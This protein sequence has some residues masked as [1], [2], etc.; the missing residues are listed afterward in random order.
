MGFCD[1]S[2]PCEW[3]GEIS[4]IQPIQDQLG[5]GYS[6]ISP[7]GLLNLQSAV[8]RFIFGVSCGSHESAVPRNIVGRPRKS[9]LYIAARNI[10]DCYY[11]VAI[12]RAHQR[13]IIQFISRIILDYANR[14]DVG[15]RAS[16]VKLMGPVHLTQIGSTLARRA[17]NILGTFG[18]AAL[19]L[20]GNM[21]S[22]KN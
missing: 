15:E 2:S 12:D 4:P 22:N 21:I 14:H 8:R 16:Q 1:S 20:I 10:N 7:K 11:I 13:D 9:A 17:G 18:Q 3:G 6:T 19:A 5:K